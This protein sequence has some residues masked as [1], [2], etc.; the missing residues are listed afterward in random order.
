MLRASTLII[1]REEVR[2]SL[3]L[4]ALETY[5]YQGKGRL[6]IYLFIFHTF[7]F[8]IYVKCNMYN[9]QPVRTYTDKSMYSSVISGRSEKS[10]DIQ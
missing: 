2:L 9:N 10:E 4:V 3:L 5:F 6:N 1:V 8:C 7:H